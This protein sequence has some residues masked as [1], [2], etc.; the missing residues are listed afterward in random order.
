MD[1]WK[2]FLSLLHS[3]RNCVELVSIWIFGRILQCNLLGLEI[4]L[5]SV[6]NYA[7]NFY[8]YGAIEMMHFT[9]DLW[10]FVL[11]KWPISFMLSKLTCG[12][13]LIILW[14]FFWCVWCVWRVC[15]ILPASFPI[16]TIYVFSL[17]F[18]SCCWSFSFT[19]FQR[20]KFLSHWIFSVVFMFS[21]SLISDHVFIIS[22]LFLT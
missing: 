10:Q 2:L 16:S 12:I 18:W 19:I 6:Y 5:L 14:L 11:R 4:S 21:F 8:S 7:F 17:L 1:E 3:G 20:S 13:I 9:F 15:V 22:F